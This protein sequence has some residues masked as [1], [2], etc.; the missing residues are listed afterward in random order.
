LSV[1]VVLD[2]DYGK[3]RL[4]RMGTFKD[5]IKDFGS[6]YTSNIVWFV[7]GLLIGIFMF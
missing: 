1:K 2:R 6:K 4:L 3:D 5:Y 7:L